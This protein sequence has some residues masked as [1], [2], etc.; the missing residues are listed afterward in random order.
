MAHNI[1][2]VVSDNVFSTPVR[3][4]DNTDNPATPGRAADVEAIAQALLNRVEYV[5]QKAGLLAEQRIWT[6]TQTMNIT[7]PGEATRAITATPASPTFAGNLYRLIDSF[8]TADA[9]KKVRVYVGTGTGNAVNYVVTTNAWWNT[10]SAQNWNKD[11]TSRESSILW[12]QD[13]ELKFYGKES[14]VNSWTD[15]S[16]SRGHIR[17]GDTLF[18]NAVTTNTGNIK[19]I[20]SDSGTVDTLT[21]DSVTSKNFYTSGNY[22]LNPGRRMFIDIP[23]PSCGKSF[24]FLTH[25]RLGDSEMAWFP[26][27]RLPPGS[28]LHS[29]GVMFQ[30]FGENRTST[31]F[32]IRRYGSA[33]SGSSSTMPTNAKID[34]TVVTA[35]GKHVVTIDFGAIEVASNEGYDVCV[36]G[37]MDLYQLRADVTIGALV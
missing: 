18:S 23:L 30:K 21:S 7:S 35:P 20:N 36:Q 31:I 1:T 22:R 25:V 17:L 16:T 2:P 8:A 13:G 4:P 37:A 19:T 15:W 32:G 26:V 33:W 9:G 3:V 12:L 24:N 10:S 34:N 6:A 11:V 27:P 29:V 28:K 5:R 14:G